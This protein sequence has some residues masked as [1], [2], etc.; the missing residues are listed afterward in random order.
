MNA[1][2]KK[3]VETRTVAQALGWGGMILGFN[4]FALLTFFPATSVGQPI[5][6]LNFLEVIVSFGLALYGFSEAQ[7]ATLAGLAAIW[8]LSNSEIPSYANWW[9]MQRFAARLQVYT[10][11]LL[12]LNVP[13]NSSIIELTRQINSI[14]LNIAFL[15]LFLMLIDFAWQRKF[16]WQAIQNAAPELRGVSDSVTGKS[17]ILFLSALTFLM[18]VSFTGINQNIGLPGQAVDQGFNSLV[19]I[20]ALIPIVIHLVAARWVARRQQQLAAV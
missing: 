14:K 1:E 4:S 8:N 5:W 18:L 2:F 7:K 9:K 11:L 13:L 19:V 20:A 15:L 16:R 6:F 3:L 12:C 10:V 17:L